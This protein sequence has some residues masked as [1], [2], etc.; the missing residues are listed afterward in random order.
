MISL[1]SVS[2]VNI[3]AIGNIVFE[4]LA[5]AEGSTAVTG[6]NGAGK[7]SLLA[8][9]LWAMYGVTPDGVP[10]SAMRRQGTIPGDDPCHAIVVFTHDGQTV[11]VERGLKGLKDSSYVKICVDGMETTLGKV[12]AAEQWI[13][14]RLGLDAEGFMTA[15]VVRQKE[16]DGLV[17]ARPADRR[18][19]VE[20][21][22]GI[23]RMSTAVRA[24]RDEENTA[25]KTADAMPGSD[26]DVKIATEAFA[27]AVETF[28]TAQ[29]DEKHA[30]EELEA[31]QTA[32]T[33]AAEVVEQYQHFAEK[34]VIWRE[35][36]HAANTAVAVAEHDR[37]SAKNKLDTAHDAVTGFDVEHLVSARELRDRTNEQI[38]QT[39]GAEQRAHEAAETVAASQQRAAATAKRRA[40]AT[41]HATSLR[42]AI[43]NHR[44]LLDT[45][46][47][48]IDALVEGAVVAAGEAS[49]KVSQL[50]GEHARL[51]A[52][53]TALQGGDSHD[54]PTC[55][56][57]L[58]DPQLL[59]DTLERQRDTIK[60]EGLEAK[61]VA[62]DAAEQARHLASEQQQRDSTTATLNTDCVALERAEKLE[63]E[64]T[65][66]DEATQSALA[67]DEAAAVEA[68]KNADGSGTL[69]NAL[70]TDLDDIHATIRQLETVEAAVNQLE[71]L[72]H[73]HT[74][75]VA[76]HEEAKVAVD[77][78]PQP[79]GGPNEHEQQVAHDT[80]AAT[81]SRWETA[82]ETHRNAERVAL[83]AKY[84]VDETERTVIAEEHKVKSR[85][86]AFAVA[87]TKTAIREALDAFRKDR[88]AKV[89]PELSEA[90]TALVSQMTDGAYTAVELDDDF[91]PSL[92]DAAGVTR[93][94]TWLSGGEESV[95]ALALRIAIGELI[96]GHRGGLLWLDE[97]LTAQDPQRRPALMRAIGGLDGR[98]IITINHVAEAT[99][100]VD[101]VFEMVPGDNGSELVRPVAEVTAETVA[102]IDTV[103]TGTNE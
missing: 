82:N 42:T 99:D 100:L 79:V 59:I 63:T 29:K 24:A 60:G 91:T 56:T 65:V 88:I 27:V 35:Q 21:L 89:A 23:E 4:P 48:N 67:N 87:E 13:N 16:L 54:C 40:D 46:P 15:F 77:S 102:A 74:L 90:A 93:P 5:A 50:R 78:I 97:V 94:V 49:E 43:H 95:V 80:A 33:V 31:A 41:N 75:A 7:T 25:R 3:R 86:E 55:E 57:P 83:E 6:S 81:R 28:T 53:I 84:R 68:R 76:A 85:A 44:T 66:E 34:M 98:Q 22:A 64:A 51:S 61:T 17:K 36:V 73:L 71:K 12:R 70:Q 30:T 1:V 8:A 10:V 96:A 18:R 39:R 9:T 101:L 52:A 103:E 32:Y 92:V 20:R 38:H 14:E 26:N 45:F 69:L 2:V 47:T 19:L 11:T 62:D 37:A 58:S 72:E